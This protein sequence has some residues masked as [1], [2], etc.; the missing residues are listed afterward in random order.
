MQVT[1]LF[2]NYDAPG[3]AIT[4]PDKYNDAPSPEAGAQPVPTSTP[5]TGGSN[6]SL[7]VRVFAS[8]GVPAQDLAVTVYPA[9]DSRQPV[10]W[11]DQAD[12]QFL[13]PPGRYDVLVQTDYAQ[14]WLRASTCEPALR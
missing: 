7:R 1:W 11:R 6:A 9:G 2:W 10:D 13:V 4:P 8:P 5:R 3:Q 12:A 14:Q